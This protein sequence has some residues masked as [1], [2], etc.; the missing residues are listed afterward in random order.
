MKNLVPEE[1][2]FWVSVITPVYNA[3]SFITRAVESALQQPETA[4]IILVEDGS[5]DNSLEVCKELAAKYDRVRLY[6]HPNGENRGAGASRNLGMQNASCEFIAFVDADNFYNPGRFS[7]T[8]SVFE[9]YQNCEGVY[10]AIGIYIEDDI[11]LQRWIKSKRHPVDQLI[12]ITKTIEPEQLGPILLSGEAGSLTL[13]GLVIKKNVLK[14][15]G[16]MSEKLRLHQDTEFIIRCAIAANLYPGQ[17]EK[18]VAMEGVHANNRFSA[19]RS[20]A[21]EYKNKMAYWLSLYHWAEKNTTLFIQKLILNCIL[22]FTR[23]H[24]YFKSFKL[25][26][27]PTRLV[28]ILRLLRLIRYPEVFVGLITNRGIH[29]PSLKST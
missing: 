2:K 25:F 9:Y 23:S 8:K 13:D 3:A 1:N 24:K 7:K 4:E 10:E 21:Q 12:T 22:K 27:L 6:R 14:K 28:W 16:Y 18:A 17:I 29:E 5:P 26:N 19:P 20:Q 15:T 11:A